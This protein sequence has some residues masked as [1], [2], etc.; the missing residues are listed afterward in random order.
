MLRRGEHDRSGSR[1]EMFS[2]PDAYGGLGARGA[3]PGG[4][5]TCCGSGFPDGVAGKIGTHGA[6][7]HR[8]GRGEQAS[9][10]NTRAVLHEAG[11]AAR[12]ARQR[13]ASDGDGER[14][15]VDGSPGT[16]YCSLRHRAGGHRSLFA[17]IRHVIAS[18]VDRFFGCEGENPLSSGKVWTL[19]ASRPGFSSRLGTRRQ[20]GT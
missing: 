1:R 13:P 2:L 12:Y 14:R 4:G 8:R 15:C 16:G 18:C 11:R 6:S 10:A 17:M 3:S 7:N 20:L 19:K 9:Q 5:T